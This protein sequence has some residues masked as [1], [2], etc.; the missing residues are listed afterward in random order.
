MRRR[1]FIKVIAGTAVAWPRPLTAYAQKP[2][3]VRL[4]RPVINLATAK[5][6]GL[7]VSSQLQQRAD[8]VIE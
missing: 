4:G 7:E 2:D 5:A 3:V 6:L 1:D 8:E